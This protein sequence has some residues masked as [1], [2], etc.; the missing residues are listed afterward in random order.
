MVGDNT[1]RLVLSSLLREPTKL[2]IGDRDQAVTRAGLLC[3]VLVQ[4][5]AMQEAG[6]KADDF[7]LTPCERGL[8]FWVEL[9]AS[10]V[11]G[12]KPV[13]IERSISDEHADAVID[14]TG[15][16]W[17]FGRDTL[18]AAACQS[19][20]GLHT[21]FDPSLVS[22]HLASDYFSLPYV[23]VDKL[24]DMAGLIFTSGTTGLPKGVPL[25]H[26]ALTYNALATARRLNLRASDR[27][28]IATPFRFISSISHFLVTSISGASFY[29]VETPLMIKDL[30]SIMNDLDISAFGGSP[31]HM[32]FLAAAGKARLPSLRWAMS[33]GDHLRPAV[34]DEIEK[35]FDDIE[36]HAVYG[37]AEL[38]GRFCELPTDYQYAKRGSVGYPIDGFELSVRTPG[39]AFCA[40]NEIGH[41]HVTG[42]LAFQGYY[43]NAAANA[44]VLTEHGFVT[45]DMGYLDEDGFLYLS[46]RSDSVFKRAGLKV[47]AQVISDAL[48]SVPEVADV[49][50][51]SE[52][53]QL[54]G[55]VPVAHVCWHDDKH[56]DH[57]TMSKTLRRSLPANHIPKRYI[58]IPKIP[59][60]GSGKVDRRKLEALLDGAKGA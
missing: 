11:V 19:L 30:L 38:G 16:R 60:T 59:R 55:S 32:Q 2:A 6:V 58:A 18:S 7:V 9:L 10:W 3:N 35:N 12:A 45:G 50:V 52:P 31:F 8:S 21:T 42:T 37:M 14:L 39:G 51:S 41:V 33:S 25:T 43:K 23:D 46:G 53:D 26:R 47:S 4:A 48:M 15:V 54:E 13:C 29:G 20:T 36:L 22:E 56:M 17:V 49:F 44:W 57:G 34:I 27:L 5:R 24:P 28:L 1:A 40:P